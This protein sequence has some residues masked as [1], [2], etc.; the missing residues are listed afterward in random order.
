MKMC[1]GIQLFLVGALVIEACS[2]S[3]GGD[4]RAP[5]D[6]PKADA[7]SKQA[8]A[9]TEEAY[10][11]KLV[12]R[13]QAALE[14]LQRA[15]RILRQSRGPRSEA[16]ASN[17]DD[18]ATVYLRTGDYAKARE[19]YNK[20]LGLLGK[21]A[22]KD[23]R[24]ASGIERRRSTLDAL[25]R[26]GHRCKEPLVPPADA[27]KTQDGGV[28]LPYL[29]DKKEIYKAYADLAEALKPCLEKA[30]SLKPIPVWTVLLGTGEIVLARTKG[31]LAGTDTARC[32][33]ST[34]VEAS[35][36]YAPKMPHF[37]ACYRN[38]TYPFLIVP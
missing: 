4:K 31:S 17:L 5:A 3:P 21:D 20:A 15:H 33:E 10:D 19:L 26:R 7:R 23:H 18:Q 16:V 32:I 9:L 13:N 37:R 28:S 24:L 34:I 14:R 30:P 22:A 11:L 38:F 1:Y 29:P 36:R 27:A 12:G 25:E 8:E 6:A 2:T 35:R